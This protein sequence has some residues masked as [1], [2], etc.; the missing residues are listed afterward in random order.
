MEEQGNPTD[1]AC[2][3]WL[4]DRSK[5]Y[6]ETNGGR[7]LAERAY[8]TIYAESFFFGLVFSISTI[9]ELLW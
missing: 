3:L 2:N 8:I 5:Q 6:I 9:A 1:A 4:M 7:T